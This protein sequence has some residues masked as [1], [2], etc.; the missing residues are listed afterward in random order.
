MIITLA[1]KQISASNSYSFL[2]IVL[3]LI[4]LLGCDGVNS[5]EDAGFDDSFFAGAQ[6]V[7]IRTVADSI[8]TID[9][10]Q[11]GS[12]AFQDKTN[13]VIQDPA[14]FV[15]FWDELHANQSPIPDLPD[16]NFSE[17]TVLAA[18]MGVQSSGGFSITISRAGTS[19]GILG[20]MI[21]EKEPG[22]GCFNIA[23]LTSPFHIVKVPKISD[24]DDVRFTTNRTQVNCNE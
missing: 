16:I 9:Q 12:Y 8:I 22:E 13:R 10:S 18:M 21:E 2:G 5:S 3:L 23:A 14:A 15:Q 17:Y 1:D 7:S 6:E 24:R 19:D 4:T 20:V 11:F